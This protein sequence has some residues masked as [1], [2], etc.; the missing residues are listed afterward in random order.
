[1]SEQHVSHLMSPIAGEFR[2]KYAGAACIKGLGRWLRSKVRVSSRRKGD[3]FVAERECHFHL[4]HAPHEVQRTEAAAGDR[5]IRVAANPG[6]RFRRYAAS[7]FLNRLWT[8]LPAE[9]ETLRRYAARAK[10]YRNECGCAMGGAFIAVTLTAL[11]L[12][13]LVYRG[14]SWDH[15]LIDLVSATAC[16][17]GASILGKMLG[18]G[19]A[20]IRL[21]LL[22]RELHRRY[23][24]TGG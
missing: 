7:E 6:K 17:F 8:S 22:G 5:Q 19:L 21:I 15:W 18:I 4:A 24:G 12:Y 3:P 20:R 11:I 9:R 16:L 13:G 1:M 2:Y 14:F 10:S 23:R